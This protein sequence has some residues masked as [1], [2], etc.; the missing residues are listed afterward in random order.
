MRIP[1]IVCRYPNWLAPA[2]DVVE[3]S[4]LL[5]YLVPSVHELDIK[6]VAASVAM[7]VSLH[8]HKAK[9]EV[10]DGVVSFNLGRIGP[11]RFFAAG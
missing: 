9:V 6:P 7:V 11:R 8:S 5:F 1:V 3:R 10:K 4:G 2:T